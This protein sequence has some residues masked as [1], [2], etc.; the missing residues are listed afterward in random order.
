MHLCAG[1]C[2]RAHVHLRAGGCVLC[3][4]CWVER[5]GKASPARG[6]REECSEPR[7]TAARSSSCFWFSV[8]EVAGR[9]VPFGGGRADRTAGWRQ[10]G[11]W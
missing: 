8:R 6:S 2:S 11:W 5:P 3:P 4:S 7:E 9:A 10:R 1:M